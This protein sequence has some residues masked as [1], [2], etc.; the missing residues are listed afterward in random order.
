MS[1]LISRTI[2]VDQLSRLQ[3]L[4]GTSS[5]IETLYP[6]E[7]PEVVFKAI[8][9]G[10]WESCERFIKIDYYAD[11]PGFGVETFTALITY[12]ESKSCYRMW[13]FAASQEEPLHMTGDF[14]EGVLTF[15]G[16]PTNMGWGMQRLRYRFTILDEGAVQLDGDRWELDGYVKYCAVVFRPD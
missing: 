7:G 13:I 14:V 8:V 2:P 1:S 4:L 6:P 9:T 3:F 5:G 16:D 15:V 10:T 12:S 11:I